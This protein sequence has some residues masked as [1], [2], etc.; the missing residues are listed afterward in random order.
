M[1]NLDITPDGQVT[2]CVALPL[3]VGNVRS[4]SL[5]DIWAGTGTQLNPWRNTKVKDYVGCGA[6][7]R[8]NH[9]SKCAGVALVEHGDFLDPSDQDCIIS[10]ARIK[11][12]EEK[13]LISSG[14]ISLTAGQKILGNKRQNE[15]E[16]QGFFS[17]IK[18]NS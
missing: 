3:P 6:C 8:K 7:P 17:N 10:I 12:A 4:L 13:G 11:L 18:S 1:A 9:C 5:S 14:S 15:M 16:K 2:P